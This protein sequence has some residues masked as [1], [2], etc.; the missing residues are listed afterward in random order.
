M[1]QLSYIDCSLID[2][3][4]MSIGYKSCKYDVPPFLRGLRPWWVKP[5]SFDTLLMLVNHY[6]HGCR[7]QLSTDWGML[8]KRLDECDEFTKII[9]FMKKNKMID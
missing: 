1:N 2:Y 3:I 8:K 6:R 9:D 5:P 4:S 7:Y